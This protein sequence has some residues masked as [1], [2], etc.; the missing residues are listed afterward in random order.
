MGEPTEAALRVLVE[1]LGLP[2]AP[3][4]HNI[5]AAAS[6]YCGL[7]AASFTKL[8]T[9]EFSRTRK[10]MS[11]LCRHTRSGKN[12]LFVKGAPESLLPR[13]SHLRLADGSTVRMTEAWR[14]K[15]KDQFS[16]MARRPLRCL[17]LAVKDT[18]L[19]ALAGVRPGAPYSRA[20][21]AVLTATG[22]FAH[23]ESGLTFTG[24]VRTP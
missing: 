8:A 9:L 23:V 20:A 12:L 11:V 17:A 24:M 5:T 2:G 3:P 16:A 4:P 21:A 19:G 22:R 6:H 13:C 15:L 10:S 7:Y 1:K 14:R 18:N